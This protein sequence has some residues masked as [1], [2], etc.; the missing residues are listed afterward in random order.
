MVERS[1]RGLFLTVE[2]G[3]LSSPLIPPARTVATIGMRWPFRAWGASIVY[4]GHD[5]LYERFAVEGVPYVVNG[6]GGKG[7]IPSGAG[8]AES[9]VGFDDA[10]GAVFVEASERRFASRF[11]STDGT[12]LDELVRLLSAS[13]RVSAAFSG[14]SRW[15]LTT[16]LRR[17]PPVLGEYAP[18]TFLGALVAR[19]LLLL[20][21]AA[22]RRPR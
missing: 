16:L 14:P 12:T 19:C 18:L 8:P 15:A 3:L 17:M 5:H 21:G 1:A 20:L 2:G 9:L 11:V 10:H 4:A 6:V 22:G 13:R 7:S